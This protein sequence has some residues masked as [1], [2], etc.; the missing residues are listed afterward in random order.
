MTL[1]LLWWLHFLLLIEC[2]SNG[3]LHVWVVYW[4]HFFFLIISV[5][6]LRYWTFCR[7]SYF[8]NAVP[9][10]DPEHLSDGALSLMVDLQKEFDIGFVERISYWQILVLISI[11]G[12]P[13]QS[14]LAHLFLRFR[15]SSVGTLF[16][17][18]PLLSPSD[19]WSV[20]LNNY[21][22]RQL[23]KQ[24]LLAIPKG[25]VWTSGG[26]NPFTS[27]SSS[28]WLCFPVIG[29]GKEQNHSHLQATQVIQMHTPTCIQFIKSKMGPR[30]TTEKRYPWCT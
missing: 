22:R 9:C 27:K 17:P 16:H 23:R 25:A 3:V 11:L 14:C 18:H 21:R 15:Y 4:F 29:Y 1:M 10:S 19:Q 6:S 24:Q 20:S 8:V 28:L 26:C 7:G 2:C 5:L 30:G 12:L 13:M